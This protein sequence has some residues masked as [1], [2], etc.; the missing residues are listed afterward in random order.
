MKNISLSEKEYNNLQQTIAELQQKLSMFQDKSFMEKINVVYQYISLGKP[1]AINENSL[2]IKRG[3]AKHI[4]SYIA[5][6]FN[7]PLDDFKDYM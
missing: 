3:S 1:I 5:D 2:S 6:D 4:I 7:A